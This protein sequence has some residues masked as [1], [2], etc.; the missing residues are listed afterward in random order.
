MKN[1]TELKISPELK[2]HYNTLRKW[3]RDNDIPYKSLNPIGVQVD[4]RNIPK[5][6]VNEWIKYATYNG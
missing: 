6:K 2:E 4:I 5:D 3:C 1:K